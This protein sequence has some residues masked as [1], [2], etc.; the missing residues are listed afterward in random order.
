M[1]V[2]TKTCLERTGGACPFFRAKQ[3]SQ[4]A[5]ILVVNHALLLT[6]V[7]VGNRVLPEYEHVI[8]DEGHHL[9]SAT[10]DS[11]S[12]RLTQS[13]V[14]RLIRE[15]GGSSSGILGH[16]LATTRDQVRPSDFALLNQKIERATDLI[17][18]IQ[19]QA[20]LFFDALA[21]FVASQR[22]GQPG[23]TYVYQERILPATRTQP[24]WDS[25]ELAWSAAGETLALLIAL[26]G[27]IQKGV[28]E[29]YAE[30]LETLEDVIGNLGNLYR[31]LTET[32]SMV[33]SLIFDP[34]ADYV[35]G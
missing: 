21:E 15:V 26:L 24:G 9:E 14:E 12:F 32:E 13:D 8:V 34:A 25:V 4:N 30:G 31:R 29:L 35:I 33:S 11:L 7:A 22:E 28:T 20:R 6:D 16:L 2:P 1:P 5:H 17:W 23:S 10:T 27:E 3:A 19:E 18:R